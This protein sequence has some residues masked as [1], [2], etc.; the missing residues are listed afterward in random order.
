MN[1][2]YNPELDKTNQRKAQE[3]KHKANSENEREYDDDAPTSRIE[4]KRRKVLQKSQIGLVEKMWDQIE[5][6]LIQT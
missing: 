3:L 6:T 4:T 5:A 2:G 1:S